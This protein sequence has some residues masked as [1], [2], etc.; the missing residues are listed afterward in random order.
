LNRSEFA[1]VL[2]R[3]V[4]GALS[5]LR[6][7]LPGESPYALAI[8][9]GQCGSYLGYAIATEE[10]LR[11]VASMYAA[12]GYR[13]KGQEWEEFDNLERL[14]LWL[15]WA[16]PDDGWHYGDFHER[17]GIAPSLANMVESGAFGRDA[18]E[19]EEFCTAVLTSLLSDA[20][21]LGM[22]GESVVVGVTSG[23]DPRDF[24]RT[25]T[26]AN[27]YATVRRLWAEHWR[28]EELSSSISASG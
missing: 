19:L 23:S 10:G 11:R 28:G 20:D 3:A 14:G 16:N 12:D 17:F 9:L 15:R 8:I 13:Y 18:E 25:A 27:G 2:Q 21:W 7:Q 4:V 5:D 22:A 6:R 24:L 1:P 26:R